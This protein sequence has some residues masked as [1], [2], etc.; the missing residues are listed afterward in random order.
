MI[1]DYR[2]VPRDPKDNAEWRKQTLENADASVVFQ[3][4]VTELCRK[5]FWYWATGFA[6][7]HEPRILDD[8]GVLKTEVPFLPWIHQIPVVD[9]ILEALGKR[10]V[11]IVKSRAQ[12][13]S[14]LVILIFTWA[15]LFMRGFIGN[16]V[17]KDEDAADKRNDMNSLLPKIDW[18]LSRLPG[19]M[20]GVKNKEWT[21]NHGAHTFARADGE[22]SINGFSCTA[23]VASGGRATAFV[24]D[25]HA[26]HPRPQDKQA[27]A[28]TQPISRCRI[29][30][31]TP[32]GMDGAF[33]E[34]VHDKSIEDPLLVLDW[35]DNPT[36]NRGLYKIVHGRPVSI[37]RDKYGPL[38]SRYRDH[39]VWSSIKAR[40]LERGY[41]LTN[42]KP[43]SPWYDEE[44]LRSGADPVLIAQEYDMDFG[45]SVSR[46]FSEALV[47]RLEK[48][49]ARLC[50]HGEFFVDREKLVGKWSDNPDGRFRLWCAIGNDGRPPHGDY[51]V[52][53]DVAG[54]VGGE[55]SSNSTISVFDRRAGKKVMSFASPAVLPY[56]LAEIAIALCRWFTS[57]DNRPAFL[58]WEVNGYGNEFKQRVE[59]SDFNYY[60]RRKPKDAPIYERDTGKAGYYT[61]KRS[62]LL[63]PY[64]EA[65]LEGFFQNPDLDSIAELRQYELGKDGEPIHVSEKSKDVS[66]AKGA[67]GDRTI[68]DSLALHA[69]QT[70]GDQ[71]FG[72]SSSSGGNFNV[73][74]VREHLVPEDSAAWRRARY[75]ESLRQRKVES[76]W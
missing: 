67:H 45:S 38:P 22:T 41:D 71:Q 21:R 31:S 32:K 39:A 66:G 60:Y 4:E 43:R 34:I 40:L 20:V 57:H 37:D 11:R 17:S 76:K 33:Y 74:N 47:I 24:L 54:G 61:T 1:Y 27:L 29:F 16:F 58:I 65:L 72:R 19:W 64:R 12:G 30:I 25:E 5:D 69:S 51:I 56:D 49:A 23:D 15:W 55:G 63:G 28:A 6:F 59:R 2:V 48:Q 36:Q 73:N 75:L 46:Y 26:K 8:S 70:F 68:S 13:A 42:G 3:K 7:V 35:K 53:S 52:A 14:W 62:A 50:L 10:D 44:C 18:L 9:K